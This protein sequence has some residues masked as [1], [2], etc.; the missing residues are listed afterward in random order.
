MRRTQPRR[1]SWRWAALA[2]AGGL[3]V[4]CNSLPT[5]YGGRVTLHDQTEQQAGLV[6]TFESAVYRADGDS[7]A[8]LV[9]YAGPAEAPTRAM[10]VRLFW[11][12]RAGRTP[13][14][15]EATNATI[16]YMVFGE[17]GEEAAADAGEVAVYTGAGF[18]YPRDT[19]G[20]KRV[21]VEIW[22]ANL[23]PSNRSSEE[24]KTLDSSLLE[25]KVIARHD[26]AAV[27]RLLHRLNSRVS[28]RLGYPRMVR[29]DGAE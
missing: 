15:A 3:L 1:K 29:V 12:P 13:I 5:R 6:R 18:V 4:G 7:G 28:H 8:T 9:A 25:G 2:L 23:Q 20:Q 24:V 27:S 21:E 17:D 26:A 11:Q 10:T 14:N 22:H 16:H 19:P